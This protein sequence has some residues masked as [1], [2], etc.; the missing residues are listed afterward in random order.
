MKEPYTEGLATHGGL[1]SCAGDQGDNPRS[2]AKRL[3]EACIGWPSSREITCSGAP[4]LLPDAEGNTV[5]SEKASSALAPRGRR[6][7]A[8]AESLCARTGRPT[9]RPSTAVARAAEGRAHA[10]YRR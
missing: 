9:D 10:R 1:E 6:P 2:Q 7:H 4:T 8:C 5:Q 3:T